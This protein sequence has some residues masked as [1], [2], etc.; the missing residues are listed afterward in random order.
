MATGVNIEEVDLEGRFLSLKNSS[1]KEQS[2]GNWK[3]KRQVL[4]GEDISF[5]FTPKYALR[6][7]QTGTVWAAGAGAT[8]SLPSNLVWQSQSS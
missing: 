5:K 2:L 8:H 3:I 1:D 6:A 7:D 4:E